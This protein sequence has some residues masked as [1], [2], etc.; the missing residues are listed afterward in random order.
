[1]QIPELTLRQKNALWRVLPGWR[2][3]CSEHRAIL[4]HHY[5]VV[6]RTLLLAARNDNHCDRL[7]AV[8]TPVIE[9]AQA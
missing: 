7:Q 6:Y 3:S 8:W 2:T 4:E 9:S 1:M 5:N